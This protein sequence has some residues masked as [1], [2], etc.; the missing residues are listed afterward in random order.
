MKTIKIFMAALIVLCAALCCAGEANYKTGSYQNIQRPIMLNRS[1]DQLINPAHYMSEG[2]IFDQSK[3]FQTSNGVYLQSGAVTYYASF[4]YIPAPSRLWNAS[5]NMCIDYSYRGKIILFGEEYYVNTID[6]EFISASKGVILVNVSNQ[7]FDSTAYGYAFKT[8]W[9]LERCTDTYCW[10]AGANLSVR[11]PGGDIVNVET[12]DTSDAYVDNLQ[13]SLIS[14][15]FAT[16]MKSMQTTI[17]VY[18][19]SNGIV[20]ENGYTAQVDGSAKTG[21]TASISGKKQPFGSA[22]NIT[23][24]KG[25]KYNQELYANASITYTTPVILNMSNYLALPEGYKVISNGTNL[26]VTD[27]W[28]TSTTTT[29]T[30]IISTTTTSSTTTSSTTTTSPNCSMTGDLPPCGVVSLA[31]VIN[32]I[33]EWSAGNAN[34]SDVIDLINA[35]ALPG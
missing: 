24:Y 5:N 14:V 9:M 17:L 15:G 19:T 31:E 16:D 34:L 10:I 23:E 20:L 13:I 18:D 7:T 3:I 12:W 29:T 27:I 35:W 22:M 8:V 1:T 11:K 21:W 2:V 4:G 30:T 32:L 6:F 33:N 26:E 28:S 25:I